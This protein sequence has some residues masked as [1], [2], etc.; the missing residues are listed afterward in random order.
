MKNLKRKLAWVVATS[1]GGICTERCWNWVGMF[2]DLSQHTRLTRDSP[3][4]PIAEQIEGTE[5][6]QLPKLLRWDLK[7]ER[8]SIC[9]EM[10]WKGP[11]RQHT[12]LTRG[13]TEVIFATRRLFE[14][15]K[16]GYLCRELAKE[17]VLGEGLLRHE[18]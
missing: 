14:T 17:K 11:L 9:P 2:R 1:Q 7:I 15:F 10:G 8:P 5:M 3:S 16:V 12:E 18:T 6:F 13:R 4:Q